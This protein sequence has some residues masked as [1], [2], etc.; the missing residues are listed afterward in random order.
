MKIIVDTNIV[1]SSL[2]SKDNS[3]KIVLL[4]DKFVF[5]SPNY[6]AIEI[7]NLKEK[8]IKTSKLGENEILEQ[9]QYVIDRIK[10]VN[11]YIIP[12]NILKYAYELCRNIDETDTPFVSLSLF[13]NAKLLTGD[14]ILY[15]GLYKLE[16]DNLISLRELRNFIDNSN[17]NNMIH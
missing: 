13:L 1:F 10:F 12:K 8:I 15:N 6:M 14:K 3:S 7:F 11:P 4:S 9:L 17:I 16:Y 2:L 5:Y